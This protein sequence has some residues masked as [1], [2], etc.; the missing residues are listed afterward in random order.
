[1][2]D[3]TIKLH[4][5]IIKT[6]SIKEGQTI[7]IG[8]GQECD[9]SIDNTAI[10]RQHISLCM[11]SGIYF[12]SD[13]GSTNG[14]FV[15][16]KKIDI[17][18]PVSESDTIIFGKFIL[19]PAD[20]MGSPSRVSA[21]V[22]TDM[23]DIDAETVFVTGKKQPPASHQFKAKGTEPKLTVIGGNASPKILPLAGS[24]SLKIG[25]DPSC[26]LVI[27]GWFVSKAQAYVIKRDSAYLLVPQRSWVGTY[28][29][30]CKISSEKIL[31]SGDIISIRGVSLRF[32]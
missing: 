8:R 12:V 25:N 14:S 5:T 16:G 28:V 18:E 1:M 13:L 19:T 24:S 23:M 26:D 11:N 27:A 22:S 10:S 32:D 29:N 21:S 31:R 9:I 2:T 17:D 30:D 7:T 4:D 20:V 15:N 6:F 3:W